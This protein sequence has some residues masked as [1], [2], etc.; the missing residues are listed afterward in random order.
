MKCWDI[1]TYMLHESDISG[2]SIRFWIPLFLSYV[3]KSII[4]GGSFWLRSISL[5]SCTDFRKHFLSWVYEACHGICFVVFIFSILMIDIILV[6][7]LNCFRIQGSK[8][9]NFQVRIHCLNVSSSFSSC[10]QNWKWHFRKGIILRYVWIAECLWWVLQALQNI[11]NTNQQGHIFAPDSM[12]WYI[13]CHFFSLFIVMSMCP[14]RPS[15]FWTNWQIFVNLGMNILQL[16]VT[17]S[18]YTLNFPLSVKGA[19]QVP[20]NFEVMNFYVVLRW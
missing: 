16:K 7:I 6:M 5:I 9:L 3:S 1:A 18:V 2:G 17:Q 14:P 13:I 4:A 12:Q 10:Q 8:L 11:P 19:T 20:L 15:N